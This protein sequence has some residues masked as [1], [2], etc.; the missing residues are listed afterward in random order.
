[1]TCFF[2]DISRLENNTTTLQLSPVIQSLFELAHKEASGCWPDNQ[3]VLDTFRLA[4]LLLKL[5]TCQ[6]WFYQ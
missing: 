1:M 2:R 6:V 4:D 5:I 3:E